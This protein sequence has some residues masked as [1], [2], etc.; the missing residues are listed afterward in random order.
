MFLFSHG[1]Y[2]PW[3]ISHPG[4]PFSDNCFKL[5]SEQSL[6]SRRKQHCQDNG[7][8]AF[9]PPSTNST[10][11]VYFAVSYTKQTSS[12]Q[13]LLLSASCFTNTP[14]LKKQWSEEAT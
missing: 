2:E 14:E 11:L 9:N 13:P 10:C 4:K 12:I 5:D 3:H 1:T 8:T 6:N 7:F